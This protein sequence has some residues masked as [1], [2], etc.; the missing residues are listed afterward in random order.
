MVRGGWIG[1]VGQGWLWALHSRRPSPKEFDVYGCMC[2]GQRACVYV[3]ARACVSQCLPV[4]LCAPECLYVVAIVFGVAV[5][6]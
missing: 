4:C 5:N 6:V 2:G 1:A 3:C